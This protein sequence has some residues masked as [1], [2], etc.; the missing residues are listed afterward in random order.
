MSKFT[1]QYLNQAKKRYGLSKQGVINLMKKAGIRNLNSKNDLRGMDKHADRRPQT[2]STTPTPTSTP[3]STSTPPATNTPAPP[4][5][6][7]YESAYTSLVDQYNNLYDNYTNATNEA[8]NAQSAIDSYRSTINDYRGQIS[9]FQNQLSNYQ[10]QVGNLQT[11]Y[12][13]ALADNASIKQERDDYEKKFGEQSAL[14]EQARAEADT[15]REQSVGQQLSGLR[16]GASAG[17]AN[18]T[19]YAGGGNLASGRSGY[20]GSASDQD[21]EIADYVIQQGGITDS[22]LS[23]EGPVVQM[24]DRDRRPPARGTASQIR[25]RTSGA[26]TG[27]YY[28]S[29]FGG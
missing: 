5:N 23:R 1:K 27:S 13:S 4:R 18:Q 20:R 14:Y 2:Q 25:D 22:V 12:Q 6:N 9:G 21:K 8:T 7:P 19:S 10:G 11:Q 17:G 24:M 16:S 3:P 26:G 28:A 29:R 15:Y